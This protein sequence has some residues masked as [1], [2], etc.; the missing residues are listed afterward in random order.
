TAHLQRIGAWLAPPSLKPSAPRAQTTG[1]LATVVIPVRNR[2]RTIKDAIES[3][4]SQ[5][6]EFKFNLIVVDNHSTDGTTA[7][8]RS[9]RDSRLV[10]IIP[11]RTDLGI[12][13][14]WNEAVNS[15]SCGR[16]AVQLDSDDI[17]RDE[18][19]LERIVNALQAGPY[20]MV[21]GSY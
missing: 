7:L 4:F 12:G 8:L 9:I 14:C 1:N 21:V 17:Y 18:T 11:E 3:V 10:H 2:E 20:A 15:Q 16:Y 6:A 5:K 13:G 19:S